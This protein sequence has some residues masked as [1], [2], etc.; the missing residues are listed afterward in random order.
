MSLIV[1]D[2][3]ADV[4]RL[5]LAALRAV[6]DACDAE[7]AHFVCGKPLF[8]VFPEMGRAHP[9]ERSRP[10]M[11]YHIKT[12]AAADADVDAWM[13]SPVQEFGKS[14]VATSTNHRELWYHAVD[15]ADGLMHDF[16]NG[17]S[18]VASI[19]YAVDQEM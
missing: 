3:R 11:S 6:R 12:K 7:P 17:D 15:K 10:W 2:L 9:D 18:S 5:T 14:L 1:C 4:E 16:E 13:P 8:P 19:L